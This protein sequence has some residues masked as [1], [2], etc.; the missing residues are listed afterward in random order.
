MNPIRPEAPPPPLKPGMEHQLRAEIVELRSKLEE[1]T[2]LARGAR[3]VST[4]TDRAN[5]VEERVR[6]EK[7]RADEA[8]SHAAEAR[9][10]MERLRV[11]VEAEAESKRAN[12][13]E[14][15][16]AAAEKYFL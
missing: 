11:A 7:E 9:A 16:A 2:Q 10:E 6:F 14:E 8:E 1:A 15:R 3:N 4:E 12:K 5:A 13:A